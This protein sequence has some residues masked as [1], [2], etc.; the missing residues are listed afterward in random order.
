MRYTFKFIGRIIGAIGIT[1]PI[2]LT[3]TAADE[4]EARGRLYFTHEHIRNVTLTERKGL[5]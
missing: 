3:L 2:T 1:Y 5:A 4:A